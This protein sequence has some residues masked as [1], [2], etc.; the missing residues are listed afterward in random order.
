MKIVI[1]KKICDKYKVNLPTVYAV[2][3][4]QNNP[5]LLEILNNS[6][7]FVEVEGKIFATDALNTIVS[8]IVTESSQDTS[9][10]RI[11][12]LVKKMQEAYPAGKS[13]H[14][15]AHY[16]CNKPELLKKMKNFFEKY[17]NYS[18]EDII[19]A[20]KRY[21][22]SF[23]GNYTYLPLLKYFISKLKT[24]EDENG[25]VHRV[26]FSPLA[27]YLENKED[28]VADQMEDWT[29]TFI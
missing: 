2:L 6:E 22:D 15:S 7:N 21:V 25:I 29:M 8:R 10:E 14:I 5:K 24:E 11:L 19:D 4:V 27:D 16:R 28:S 20:T 26:E 12:D 1:D 23:N 3:A 18:D 17:G 9:E 13:P